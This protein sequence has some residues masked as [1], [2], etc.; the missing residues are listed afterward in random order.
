MSS[1]DLRAARVAREW[2]QVVAADRLGVSQPSRHAEASSA[3]AD[4]ETGPA[5][6]KGLRPRADVCSAF[7]ARASRP[8]Q[9]RDSRERPRW[10]RIPRVR[11]PAPQ[12]LDAKNP[13]EVLLSALAQNDLEPRLV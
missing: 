12:A 9:C 3:P 11:L 2:S 13:G 4:S 1:H 10:L 8:P 7:A 6:G 5:C